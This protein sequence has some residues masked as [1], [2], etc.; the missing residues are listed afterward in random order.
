[1]RKWAVIAKYWIVC[2]GP[3][4]KADTEDDIRWPRK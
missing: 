1:M 3:D 4:G 2:N